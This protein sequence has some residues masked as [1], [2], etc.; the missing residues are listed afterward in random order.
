M[1]LP[2]VGNMPIDRKYVPANGGS[3]G[4]NALMEAFVDGGRHAAP[5]FEAAEYDIVIEG[6]KH[7]ASRP[8]D[9]AEYA[10]MCRLRAV[11]RANVMAGLARVV[12]NGE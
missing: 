5:L 9:D 11:S 8:R 1:F 3:N 7:K 2:D 12:L 4:K 10:R 6:E